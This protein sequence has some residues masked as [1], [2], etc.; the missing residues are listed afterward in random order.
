MVKEQFKQGHPIHTY[1]LETELVLDLVEQIENTNPEN[2]F[3]KFYNLFNHLSTVERR[4]ERKENQLFPFLEE[5]GWTG[6]S[7]NMCSFHDTIREMFR[8]VRKN[9]DENNLASAWENAK[10]TGQNLKNLLDVEDRILFPNAME[11]LTDEDW[12][13]V[14]QGEEEIGWMLKEA[15]EQYPN[16]SQYIHPSEDKV[17][18]TDMV[19][20]SDALHYDEG[21]LTVE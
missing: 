15:P 5:K 13:K 4:F 8:I 19:F 1:L 7:R 2:E 12:I 14:R 20:P 10:Y 3:Q 21:Y 6:P 18:R 11:I 9:I 17:R 16:E